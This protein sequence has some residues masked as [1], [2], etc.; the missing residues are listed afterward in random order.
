MDVRLVQNL[1]VLIV[2]LQLQVLCY[3]LHRA[4]A[5][6]QGN[7]GVADGVNVLLESPDLHLRMGELHLSGGVAFGHVAHQF[8]ADADGPAV[9]FADVYGCHADAGALPLDGVV[10]KPGVREAD[11][12]VN[13]LHSGA[14]HIKK[15]GGDPDMGPV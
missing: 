1:A 4:V 5:N 10:S 9:E 14:G 8:A 6:V 2:E 13:P 15:T 3:R 7:L 11:N 12:V